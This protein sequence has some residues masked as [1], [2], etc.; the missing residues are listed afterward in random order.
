MHTFAMSGR[1][2]SIE[3]LKFLLDKTGL[4]PSALARKAGLAT[5]TL[6]RPLNN[7]GHQFNLSTTTLEHLR[8]ATGYEFAPFLAQQMDTVERTLDMLRKYDYQSG[9]EHLYGGDIIDGIPVMGE[10]AAGVW[11]EVQFQAEEPLSVL[12][13]APTRDQWKGH[14]LGA[15]VRGESLNKIARDGDVLVVES[16]AETGSEPRDGD[17]VLVERRRDQNG[18]IEVTAKRLKKAK[19]V[20]E[21]DDPRFQKPL[22]LGEHDGEIVQI[23]GIVHYI[24]RQP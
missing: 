11:R 23:I 6:T 20:P 17:L 2:P 7:P 1:D 15:V 9:Q 18:I 3:Y 19:L 10:V 12:F 14:L 5:T 8:E 13:L 4:S 24:I 22:Q 21:S 16:I